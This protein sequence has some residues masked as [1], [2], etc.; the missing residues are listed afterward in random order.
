MNSDSLPALAL[1]SPKSWEDRTHG[2]ELKGQEPHTENSKLYKAA[3]T[4]VVQGLHG[5]K[6]AGRTGS[7][8]QEGEDHPRSSHLGGPSLQLQVVLLPTNQSGH[9]ATN[10]TV[11]RTGQ[12]RKRFGS[13]V[14]KH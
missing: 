2:R 5:K 11:R 4:V 9:C 14:R 3:P 10:G 1:R 13:D 7:T 6:P 8:P 12:R